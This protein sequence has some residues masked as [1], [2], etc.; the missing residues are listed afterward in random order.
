MDY[1]PFIK[2]SMIAIFLMATM[3]NGDIRNPKFWVAAI[4]LNIIVNI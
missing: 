2:G 1:I 4:S 3:K